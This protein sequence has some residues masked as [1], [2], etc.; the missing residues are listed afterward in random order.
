MIISSLTNIPQ[1]RNGGW[2]KSRKEGSS[3]DVQSR[4]MDDSDFKP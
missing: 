1:K 2:N 4:L 3:R